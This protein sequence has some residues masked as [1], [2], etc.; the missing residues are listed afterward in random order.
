MGNENQLLKAR[1]ISKSF[2]KAVIALD[3]VQFDLRSGE[4]HALLG[5][6]G[7]GKSTLIKVLT[8][9]EERDCE[10]W[11]STVKRF[12]QNPHRKHSTRELPLYIRK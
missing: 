4:I 5:E 6:N 9:V 12:I 8:G 7:A 10:P 11:N 1:H 3:Y 2:G